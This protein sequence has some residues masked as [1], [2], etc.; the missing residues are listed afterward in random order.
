MS[1]IMLRQESQYSC[2]LCFNK[3]NRLYSRKKSSMPLYILFFLTKMPGKLWFSLHVTFFCE[4]S[5][6]LS[7]L[8]AGGTFLMFFLNVCLISISAIIYVGLST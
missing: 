6:D 5:P 2:I 8:E 3:K 7:S 1:M 4:I